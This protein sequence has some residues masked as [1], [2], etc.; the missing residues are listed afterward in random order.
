MTL[1]SAFNV[2]HAFCGAVSLAAFAYKLGDRRKAPGNL[3]LRGMCSA[4]LCTALASL[5]L[6]PACYVRIDRLCGVPNLASLLGHGLLIVGALSSHLT[7][8]GWFTPPEAV[9]RRA[10]RAGAAYA[11]ALATVVV[12]FLRTPLPGEHPNGCPPCWTARPPDLRPSGE[13]H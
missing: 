13:P 11:L 3:A 5:C 9:R 4:R 6:T 10:V 7:V 2:T 8:I 12:L 1:T